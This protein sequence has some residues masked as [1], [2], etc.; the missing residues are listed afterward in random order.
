MKRRLIP[1]L[2]VI[3]LG[4]VALWNPPLDWLAHTGSWL[5]VAAALALAWAVR[6]YRSR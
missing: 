5:M 2:L 1:L 4:L 3:A 6:Q